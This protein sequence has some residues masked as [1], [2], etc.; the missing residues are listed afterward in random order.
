MM[1]LLVKI[2]IKIMK[3]LFAINITM[4]CNLL[5]N[6]FFAVTSPFINTDLHILHIKGHFL[7]S[8]VRQRKMLLYILLFIIFHLFFFLRKRNCNKKAVSG[9]L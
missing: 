6:F 7:N 8:K 3:N 9:H 2:S 5:L 1:P 4:F